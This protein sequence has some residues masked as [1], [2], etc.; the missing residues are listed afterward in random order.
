MSAYLSHFII[1]PFDTQSKFKQL[2]TNKQQISNKY[3]ESNRNYLHIK[4]NETILKHCYYLLYFGLF[5]PLFSVLGL[6]FN[7]DRI[8]QQSHIWSR[9]TCRE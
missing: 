9:K 5:F 1:T 6:L 2:V 8:Y 7:P 3:M 4:R